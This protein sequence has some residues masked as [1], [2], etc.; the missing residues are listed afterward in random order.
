MYAGVPVRY[1][2]GCETAFA[3]Q[4]DGKA[5]VGYVGL[6]MRIQKDV[7]RFQIAMDDAERVRVCDCRSYAFHQLSCPQWRKRTL[8]Q[9]RIQTHALNEIH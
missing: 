1:A 5:K 9:S 7:G 4:P 6:I 8:F 2:R 3:L